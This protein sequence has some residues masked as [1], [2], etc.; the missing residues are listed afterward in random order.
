MS[1]RNGQATRERILRAALTE[2]PRRG[3]AG[4]RVDGIASRAK[5]N[6]ALLY[7]YYGDKERLF[8]QVLESKMEELGRLRADPER[9][10]ET[11]GDV[12][13]LYAAN[14]WLVRLVLWEALDFGTKPVPNEEARARRLAEHVASLED[15]QRAG[16][17]GAAPAPPPPPR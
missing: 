16:G 7:Q 12:F 6:K 9:F 17:G 13:A 15:A 2:F 14:P 10:V 4:T 1:R 8:Q 11:T 3:F 5:V